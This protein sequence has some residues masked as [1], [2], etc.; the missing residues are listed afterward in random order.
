MGRTVKVKSE[1]GIGTVFKLDL[2]SLCKVKKNDH[3]FVI[4]SSEQ[5]KAAMITL[6]A[7]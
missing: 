7:L 3:V 1:I 4:L 6:S 2:K 5:W